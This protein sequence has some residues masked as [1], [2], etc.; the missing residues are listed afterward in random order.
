M[1]VDM[2]IDPHLRGLT[3]ALKETLTRCASDPDVESV[4]DTRTGTRRIEAALEAALRDAGLEGAEPDD[5]RIAAART[6]EGLLKRARRAAAPVR[7]L[8]VQRGLLKRLVAELGAAAP[9]DGLNGDLAEQAARLD[10]ALHAKRDVRVAP[11]KK[12]ASKWAER[13]DGHCA[14]FVDAMTQRQARHAR[15]PDAARAALDAFARLA[16]QMQQLDAGNLHDFR[17][18]AK[19]ARYMAEAGMGDEYAGA[20]GKALKKLQDAIGDWHDW[21]MLAEDAHKYLGE[22]GA[23]LTAAIE[24]ERDLRFDAAMKLTTRMR[25]KL[26][27][28]WL[29]KAPARQ[30]RRVAARASRDSASNGTHPMPQ[31]LKK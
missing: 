16:T 5:P 19:K 31:S 8:D 27:G 10:R 11:L 13:L 18:G 25:G 20:V 14:A 9:P 26:M 28:E 3:D 6:W 24:G 1:V 23:R 12:I 29:A 2:R 17:K 15:K 30:T 7:D 22:N 4:H 21:L